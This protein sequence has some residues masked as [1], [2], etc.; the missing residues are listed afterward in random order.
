[1]IPWEVIL[2]VAV[3]PNLKI[4]EELSHLHEVD[5]DVTTALR[6]RETSPQVPSPER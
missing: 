4:D 1:M 5:S 2:G 3:D 6:F